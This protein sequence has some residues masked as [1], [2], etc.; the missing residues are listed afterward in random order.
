[1][2]FKDNNLKHS[3]QIM[4]KKTRSINI[5]VRV[6]MALTVFQ[7]LNAAEKILYHVE[8]KGVNDELL[9]EKL[10]SYSLTQQQQDSPPS[11][12]FVLK[13]R[14]KKDLP[15]FIKLLRANAYF[16]SKIKVE[17][18]KHAEDIALIFS[19]ELGKPYH[20]QQVNIHQNTEYLTKPTLKQ[21]NLELEQP[22]LTTTILAAEQRLLNY[23]KNKAYAFAKLCPRKVVVNHDSQTV[24][25]D[26]CLK[27][28]QQVFIGAVSFTGNKHLDADFLKNLI[29]WQPGTLYNQKTLDGQ[30][31]KLIDSRL[32]K[33]ARLNLATKADKNGHF[34]VEFELTERLPRTLSAGLRLTTDEELFLLR[35]A[36]EHRN[37]WRH[38]ENIDIE[39]N[40]SM[41]K[42]S[43]ETNFRKPVFYQPENTL[44]IDSKFIREDTDA[45]QSLRTEFIMAV[46]HQI[47][48]KQRF[49]MG[50]AYQFSHITEQDKAT[51]NFNLI[52]LPA[53][54]SWDFSNHFLEPTLGG[55]LWIDA[56]PFYNLGSGAT[57]HKQKIRYNHYLSLNSSNDLILAGRMII[58]NIWGTRTAD[59]PA[60][61]RYFAGGNDTVRGYGFQSLSPKDKQ[62][63]LIGGR[64]LFALS[65][66]LRN[67]IT[68]KIG[69][70]GFLDAGHAYAKA[71]Q[72][73][74]NLKMGAGLGLRYKTPMG[75]IRFDLARPLNK[76]KEDD[77]FQI[78]MSIG[79]AF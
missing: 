53:H 41:I 48:K 27:T 3:L 16:N 68:Q 31:L 29:N 42:S 14:A 78:Y 4:A 38:G 49:N 17:S 40:L 15:T 1:M 28:G 18:K 7:P 37:L 2:Q 45:F 13:Q 32:F 60:D 62:G 47:S 51:E 39:F 77:E 50:I 61:L 63:R 59:I 11:S 64:S 58:G 33:V 19:F 67:W 34:P 56:H 9:K 65:L 71:Y 35:F 22:A 52:S 70:V 54:F 72:D 36:W 6:I 57:F 21:L 66:E 12:V 30:R 75:A 43:L 69:I 46:E 73:F 5:I 20:L 25:V 76:R 44:V 26:L 24:I 55:R 23:A 74:E 8:I 10:L 79:H